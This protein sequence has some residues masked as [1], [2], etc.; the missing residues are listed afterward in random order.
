MSGDENKIKKVVELN[1]NCHYTLSYSGIQNSGTTDHR[2]ISLFILKIKNN[3]RKEVILI[4]SFLIWT[5]L[6]SHIVA[7]PQNSATMSLPIYHCKNLKFS[8]LNDNNR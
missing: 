4:C 7:I 1:Q 5:Q 3:Y 2:I 6:S 8:F